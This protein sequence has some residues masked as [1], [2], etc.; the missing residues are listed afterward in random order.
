MLYYLLRPLTRLAFLFFYRRIRVTGRELVPRKVP[1]IF[2]VNHPTAFVEPC[3]LACYSGRTL[4]FMTRGDV[5]VNPWIHRLLRQVHLIPVYRFRDGYGNLKR[6][7]QSFREARQV[8]K[9]KGTVLIMAEGGMRHE[10][11]LRPIQRGAARLA[12]DTLEKDGV[13]DVLIQPVAVNYTAAAE[14]RGEMMVAFLPP[15]SSRSFWPLYREKPQAALEAVTRKIGDD[16]RSRVVHIERVEDEAI[17]EGLLELLREMDAL[18]WWKVLLEDGHSLTREMA[19]ADKVFR[20]DADTRRALEHDWQNLRE[21]LQRA[22]MG[23]RELSLAMLVSSPSHPLWL[24]AL[25]IIHFLACLPHRVPV[26]LARNLTSRTVRTIEFRSSVLFGS[27]MFISLFWYALCALLA[28]QFLGTPA[29]FAVSF[30]WPITAVLW[31]AT[32]GR[33]ESLEARNRFHRLDKDQRGK[34]VSLRNALM[35]TWRRAGIRTE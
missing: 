4:H 31:L 34:L 30:L 23:I 29:F 21:A 35:A 26:W 32:A 33:L 10:K 18:P 11:R 2:T 8:L 22:D 16:L 6:N 28:M 27:L 13:E 5:F 20:L 7:E 9:D 17:T 12:F 3:F 15:F 25:R 19:V 14:A 24:F 1:V